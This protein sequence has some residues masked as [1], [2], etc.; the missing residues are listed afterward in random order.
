MDQQNKLLKQEIQLRRHYATVAFL[1]L[2]SILITSIGFYVYYLPREQN[3]NDYVMTHEKVISLTNRTIY[4]CQKTINESIIINGTCGQYYYQ[5]GFNTVVNDEIIDTRLIDI[6]CDFNHYKCMKNATITYQKAKKEASYVYY[7]KN[8]PN[9]F[10][11]ELYNVTPFKYTNYVAIGIGAICL[12]YFVVTAYK[13]W[14]F[15][16]T[17]SKIVIADSYGVV[18][19]K[20]LY[21]DDQE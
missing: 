9:D 19:Y 20:N 12:I 14:Q 5:L 10:K 2:I 11:Y 8:N 4:E 7:D 3:N 6:S 15:R 16:R 13:I 17:N 18:A 1:S 21:Y